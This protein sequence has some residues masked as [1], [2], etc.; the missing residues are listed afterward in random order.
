MSISIHCRELGIDCPYEVKGETENAAERS[1][2]RGQQRA[3]KE[4]DADPGS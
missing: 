4:R 2:K 3:T 1:W